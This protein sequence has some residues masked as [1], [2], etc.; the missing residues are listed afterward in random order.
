MQNNN[1][2]Y[3]YGE[4][5]YRFTKDGQKELIDNYKKGVTSQS[6]PT[7]NNSSP[8]NSLFGNMNSNGNN[9]D[10]NNNYSNNYTQNTVNTMQQGNN[11]NAQSN[12]FGNF[13]ISKILPMMFK[14]NTGSNDLIN[15][16]AP[17]LGNNGS[18]I[19]ELLNNTLSNNNNNKSKQQDIPINENKS[20]IGAGYKK[21]E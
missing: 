6:T 9:N 7:Q 17:M 2:E 12:P 14:K 8:Q 11:T 10:F 16:L 18:S 15:L 19:K 21:V 13:D 4:F 1:I 3:P 5:P 20:N